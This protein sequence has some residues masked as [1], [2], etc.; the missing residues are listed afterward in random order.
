MYLLDKS[1]HLI[2][3]S[4]THAAGA[5]RVENCTF[6]DD[7]TD[8][9]QMRAGTF[10][11]SDDPT[12]QIIDRNSKRAPSPLEDIPDPPAN[13]RLAFLSRDDRWFAELRNVRL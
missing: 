5:V 3:V 11:Y 7:A 6:S 4:V 9:F 1:S 12:L 2:T 8:L 10:F 13:P